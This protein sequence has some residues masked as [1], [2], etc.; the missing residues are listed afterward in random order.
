MYF[1]LQNVW[2]FRKILGRTQFLNS[3]Q[4]SEAELIPSNKLKEDKLL[5]KLNLLREIVL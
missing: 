2:S 5:H 1:E 4:E 3:S